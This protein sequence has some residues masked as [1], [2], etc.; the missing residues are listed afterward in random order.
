MFYELY[1]GMG[2]RGDEWV[3]VKASIPPERPATL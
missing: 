1:S 2:E 3:H